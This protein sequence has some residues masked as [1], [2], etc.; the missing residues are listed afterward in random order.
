MKNSLASEMPLPSS[1][2][3]ATLADD[4][5]NPAIRNVGAGAEQPPGR[6]EVWDSFD[7]EH[8]KAISHV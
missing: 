7:I 2:H 6:S 3:S 4:L 8:E 5:T 1:V